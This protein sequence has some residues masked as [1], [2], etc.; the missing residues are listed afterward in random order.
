MVPLIRKQ[1]WFQNHVLLL[2]LR[3]YECL[4]LDSEGIEGD[5]NDS[6]PVVE[7]IT[8]RQTSLLPEIPVSLILK[9]IQV[10]VKEVTYW[11]VE[12]CELGVYNGFSI[13]KDIALKWQYS[14]GRDSQP[15]EL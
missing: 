9:R 14:E 3:W 13:K 6:V 7:S 12:W 10:E 1:F 11:V 8:S 4:W 2:G 15:R 5:A